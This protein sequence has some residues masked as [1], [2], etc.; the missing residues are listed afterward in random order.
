MRGVGRLTVGVPLGSPLSLVLFL[1]WMAPI[2]TEMERRIMEEVPGVA[3]ELPS[4]VN[5][6]H[7]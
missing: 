5:D 6:L 4:Y 7:C 1:A 3:V 2:L